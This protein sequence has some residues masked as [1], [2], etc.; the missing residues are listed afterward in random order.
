[1]DHNFFIHS[2]CRWV[3]RLLPRPSYCKW[4]CNEHWGTCLLKLWFS[5]SISSWKRKRQPTPVFV[6]GK[7]HGHRSLVGYRSWGR[8]RARHDLAMKQQQGIRSVVGLLGHR[9]VLVLVFQE[10]SILFS[11]VAVSFFLIKL[12]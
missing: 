2:S 7:S 9:V 10:I 3:S 4:C 5:Q 1:M 6:P 11:I 12:F 8:K